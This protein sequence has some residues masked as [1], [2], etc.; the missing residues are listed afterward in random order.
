MNILLENIITKTLFEFFKYILKSVSKE[1]FAL[2][3][4]DKGIQGNII[5]H[6]NL[7]NYKGYLFTLY[8]IRIIIKECDIYNVKIDRHVSIQR[9]KM[10]RSNVKID[11]TESDNIHMKKDDILEI[12]VALKNKSKEI[13][14]GISYKDS[15]SNYHTQIL[16]IKNRFYRGGELEFYKN[17]HIRGYVN[18]DVILKNKIF[19]LD[20]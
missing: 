5:S 3:L 18:A 12:N 14:I 15:N 17:N 6:K 16:H 11:I 7:P 10:I 4:I 1:K 2:E 9:I 8:D 13:K 19:H 20:I